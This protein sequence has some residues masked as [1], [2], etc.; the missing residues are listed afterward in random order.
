MVANKKGMA[1]LLCLSDLCV[2]TPSVLR[3]FGEG[4]GIGGRL[5]PQAA[6]VGSVEC[7]P[8]P[9]GEAAFGEVTGG[10]TMQLESGEL[11]YCDV[12]IQLNSD[13]INENHIK[14]IID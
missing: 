10:G 2:M 9:R 14:L 6:A 7:E 4:P 5:C 11:E 3:L 8:W 1:H 12:E 13:E